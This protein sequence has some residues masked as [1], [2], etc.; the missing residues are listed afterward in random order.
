MTSGIYMIR[1]R[2]S[3][4]T[5]IGRSR[6]IEERWWLH[7]RH[8]ELQRDR[9]PL[10]RAMRK[11]GNE[12]FE[13]KVLV[14][15][16]PRLHVV[17]EHQF[18][19]DWGTV[20]PK[21]YNV[22][23]ANGGRPSREILAEMGEAERDEMVAEMRR[24]ATAMHTSIRERREADPEYDAWY[25]ERMRQAALTREARRKERFLVD[26]EYVEREANR[27]R[28]GGIKSAATRKLRD[29]ADPERAR[30]AHETC[31][32]AGKKAR[33]SDP[34]TLRAAARKLEGK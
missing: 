18:M 30:K 6:N 34:R 21:G 14:T 23:G 13:W 32:A 31:V 27:R 24:A 7:K 15:A 29:D 10:H 9:S 12:A 16:P 25:K 20:V 26:P 28:N 3:G 22:G 2:D 8:T 33:A 19:T 1:H 5:Y 11:Y 17:L 4:K